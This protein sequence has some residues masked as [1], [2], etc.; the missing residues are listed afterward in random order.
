MRDQHDTQTSD[1]MPAK[2]GRPCANLEHGPM[3]PAERARLYRNRQRNRAA[4]VRH[5]TIS[6]FSLAM[7]DCSDMVLIEAIRKERAFLEG[8]TNGPQRGQGAAPSRKRLG[9]LI[10]ELARRYPVA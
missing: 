9:S 5:A 1:L 2:R 3:T 4:H 7:A 8:L 10:A 6:T